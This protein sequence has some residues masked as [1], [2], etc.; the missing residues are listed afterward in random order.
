MNKKLKIALYVTGAAIAVKNLFFGES[1][2][3]FYPINDSG[4]LRLCD[5]HGCGHYGASRNGK[6][7]K[8]IDFKVVENQPMKAPFDC[9]IVRYGF[10][11]ENNTTYILVEIK[12]TGI[13]QNYGAKLMYIK[14]IHSTGTK[15]AKGETICRADNIAKLYDSRM[16][17]HVHFEVFKDG[18]IIDPTGFFS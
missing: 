13:Y 5:A 12:G 7:H 3:N 9:E 17:P 18:K 6:L 8:G 2:T 4:Q 1:S 16:T 15:L 11:Y 14:R 10:P